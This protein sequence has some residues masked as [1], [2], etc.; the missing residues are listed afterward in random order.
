VVNRAHT[1]IG[2]AFADNKS[3]NGAVEEAKKA[4]QKVHHRQYSRRRF[5]A[6]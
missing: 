6:S 3:I 5:T 2:I 4:E 1:S